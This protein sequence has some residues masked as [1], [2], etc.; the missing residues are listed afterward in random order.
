MIQ[1]KLL[2]AL[3]IGILAGMVDVLPGV[4]QGV[5]SRITLAGFTFWVGVAFVVAYVSLPLKAWLKGL[6]VAMVLSIPGVMLISIVDARS[7]V[8]MLI[9]TAILGPVIG[10]LTGRLCRDKTT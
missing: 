5:N 3:S 8:P 1:R 9:I 7:V 10:Y 6:V 4:I 2:I